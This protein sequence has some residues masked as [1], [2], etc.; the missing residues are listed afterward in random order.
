MSAVTKKAICLVTNFK[1]KSGAIWLMPIMG[2]NG[3]GYVVGDV[4]K[5][6]LFSWRI[7]FE[8]HFSYSKYFYL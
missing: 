3:E 4:L 7:P 6:I 8:L 2:G 1:D 5:K